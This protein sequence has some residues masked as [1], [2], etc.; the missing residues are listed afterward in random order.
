MASI[1]TG[2]DL[3]ATTYSPIG[4]VFQIEYAQKA[5]ENSGTAIALRCADGIV[6]AVEKIVQ[7]KMLEPGSN[8]RIQ[9]IDKH[10]GMVSAGLVPDSR[11]IANRARRE[12]AAYKEF[13]DTEISVKVLNERVSAFVQM[14]TLYSYLRPFGCAVIFGGIDSKGPQLYMIE[15][16]GV[17][18]GYF[19]CALG[20]AAQTAKTEIEKLDLKKLSCEEGVIEAAKIIYSVH[21]DLKDRLF[22]LELSWVCP[23][24]ENTHQLVPKDL[25][26]KAE[27]KAKEAQKEESS[28]SGSEGDE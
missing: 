15:P 17:S 8:R 16:S 2:Y 21:D 12:A 6:F 28:D 26:E 14:Y 27:S 5:V 18:W 10:I 19:G 13:Y 11:Q 22:D 25:F 20:K 1:G 3:S 24:S 23:Q 9:T 7:S 4:R